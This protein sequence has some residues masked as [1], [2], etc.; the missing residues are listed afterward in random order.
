MRHRMIV[1]LVFVL[2]ILF[3]LPVI[4]F[5]QIHKTVWPGGVY[6]VSGNRGAQFNSPGW[7]VLNL[8]CNGKSGRVVVEDDVTGRVLLNSTVLGH[9]QFEIV[10]PHAGDYS[11]YGSNS[12]ES[13]V[14][15][16]QVW[17]P[18]ATTTVQDVSYLG[19]SAMFLLFVILLIMLR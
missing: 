13:L 6:P 15:T 7:A 11:I 14:C 3:L 19:S 2:G 1:S 8:T 4:E 16:D 18:Y 12:N 10:L 17:K 5:S 9:A